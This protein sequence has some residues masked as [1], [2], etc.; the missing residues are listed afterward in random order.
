[1]R[2]QLSPIKRTEDDIALWGTP[3]VGCFNLLIILRSAAKTEVLYLPPVWGHSTQQLCSRRVTWTPWLAAENKCSEHFSPKREVCILLQRRT[4]LSSAVP[5]HPA[6]LKGRR[7]QPQQYF[8]IM[9]LCG[10]TKPHL[11]NH[12]TESTRAYH[13]HINGTFSAATSSFLL[14]KYL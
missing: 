4:L 6:Q 1:M 9:V 11:L 2:D 3:V 13:I 10:L 8:L 5:P 14:N 7:S 12:G